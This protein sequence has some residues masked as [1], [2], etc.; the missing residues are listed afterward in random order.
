MLE[1]NNRRPKLNNYII[2]KV[3]ENAKEAILNVNINCINLAQKYKWIK[4]Y[5][6]TIIM[7]RIPILRQKMV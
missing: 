4:D 5:I 1:E 2:S 7:Y 3:K 6:C